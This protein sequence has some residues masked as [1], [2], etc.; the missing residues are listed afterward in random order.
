MLPGPAAGAL[1][2][3]PG[4]PTGSPAARRTARATVTDSGHGGIIADGDSIMPL[5]AANTM[6]VG[7]GTPRLRLS[8]HHVTSFNLNL[9]ARRRRLGRPPRRR[10]RAGP[11]TTHWMPVSGTQA[12]LSRS[13]IRLSHGTTLYPVHQNPVTGRDDS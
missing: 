3:S 8:L 5:T 13:S 1:G 10:R 4:G 9:S 7:R 11:E 6:K 2:P 12:E